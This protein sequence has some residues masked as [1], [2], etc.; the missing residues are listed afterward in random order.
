MYVYQNYMITIHRE[1][2]YRAAIQHKSM[3]FLSKLHYTRLPAN[4]LT[5][6]KLYFTL[7]IAAY[8]VARE[9]YK[10]KAMQL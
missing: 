5:T 10:V 6:F 1:S 4:R 7:L 8:L 2:T 9:L 3:S